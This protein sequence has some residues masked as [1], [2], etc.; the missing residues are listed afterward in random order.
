M[1]QLGVPYAWGGGNA[2]GPTRGIRDGG[3]ADAHGDYRKVGFDCSGLMI[4]AFAA[5]G[6][7]LPH[8]SGYQ[9]SAGRRVPLSQ[10]APGDMLFWA[11]RGHIHHVA[12][13]IGNNQMIEAPYSGSR[14]RIASVRYGGIVGYAT[15]LL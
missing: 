10:K 7:R 9:A 2:H 8:Y 3:V 12:L 15:R 11:T 14:V 4:Y 1:S 6:K 13:Y 5:A